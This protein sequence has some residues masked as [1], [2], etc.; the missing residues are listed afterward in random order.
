MDRVMDRRVVWAWVDCKM[1]Y[2]KGG[3]WM[4]NK[5]GGSVRSL[6]DLGSVMGGKGGN[7]VGHVVGFNWCWRRR[8]RWQM[9]RGGWCAVL[10]CWWTG[11]WGRWK[12]WTRMCRLGVDYWVALG[13]CQVVD[14]VGSWVGNRVRVGK[15]LGRHSNWVGVKEVVG[16]LVMLASPQDIWRRPNLACRL[17]RRCR[18]SGLL[19]VDRLGGERGAVAHP[20]AVPVLPGLPLFLEIR[21]N[22]EFP[23]NNE[24]LFLFSF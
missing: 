9:M 22:K 24:F 7:L 10:E 4:S 6:V 5:M 3:G 16:S 11:R 15:R 8:Q 1:L 20:V 21:V 18:T 13:R 2:R 12:I 14:R 19:S 17:A 23:A